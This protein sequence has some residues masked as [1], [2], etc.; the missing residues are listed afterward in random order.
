[1]QAWPGVELGS[2]KKQLQLSGQGSIWSHDARILSLAPQPLGHAASHNNNNN[3]N[4]NNDSD[5]DKDSNHDSGRDSA[6]D[7]ENDNDNNNISKRK[8][9]LQDLKQSA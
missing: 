1:M 7:N 2:T 9:N 3:N 4:N 6:S 5:S 8:T